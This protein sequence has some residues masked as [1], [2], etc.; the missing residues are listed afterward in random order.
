MEAEVE[1]KIEAYID[2]EIR[3]TAV[4]QQKKILVVPW[5]MQQ[6]ETVTLDI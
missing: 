1:A 4:W 3:R 5:I 2:G 6:E